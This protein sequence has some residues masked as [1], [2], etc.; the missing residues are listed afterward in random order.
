MKIDH[1]IEVTLPHA[2]LE[3]TETVCRIECDNGIHAGEQSRK[4]L[5]RPLHRDR[6]FRIRLPLPERAGN[7]RREDNVS[8]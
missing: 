5:I 1:Q 4:R 3:L 2:G 6:D 8:E 7:G